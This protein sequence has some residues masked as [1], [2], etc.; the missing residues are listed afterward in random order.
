M[1]N[2]KGFMRILEASIAILLVAGALIAL[3]LNSGTQVESNIADDI[4]PI[5][6]EM[7][8]NSS[9]RGEILNYSTDKNYTD[10]ANSLILNDAKKFVGS[11]LRKGLGFQV[12]ICEPEKICSL[13]NALYPNNASNIYTG[14]RVISTSLEQNE[15]KPKKIKIF[16]WEN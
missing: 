16:L 2:K 14:E 11:R 8:A 10:S 4:Q 1:V 13:D 7:A 9:L 15:F 3:S 6:S 5:L 12:A